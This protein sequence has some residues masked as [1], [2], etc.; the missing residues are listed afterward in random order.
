MMPVITKTLERVIF[1]KYAERM[2]LCRVSK[3]ASSSSPGLVKGRNYLNQK[4]RTLPIFC[5]FP[6]NASV[7][8]SP[9]SIDPNV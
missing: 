1:Y 4:G 5:L 9:I 3:R 2:N 8:D 7:G 6:H